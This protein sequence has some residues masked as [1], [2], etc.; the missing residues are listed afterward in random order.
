M[1]ESPR[2]GLL[3]V[4]AF[5]IAVCTAAVPVL[6]QEQARAASHARK[7]LVWRVD[8]PS[9][10]SPAYLAGSI[11]VLTAAHYPLNETMERAFGGA[12]TLVEEVHLDEL[13]SAEGAALLISKGTYTDGRT[14]ENTISKPT[15][16]LIVERLQRNGIPIAAMEHMKP[17]VIGLTL[18]ALEIQKSGFD[19]KL[20][21]DRHFFEKAKKAGKEIRALETVAYQ[22]ERFD[23]MPIATQ[24]QMLRAS[25]EDVETQLAN[26]KALADAWAAGDA[27]ATER[28]LLSSLKEAPHAYERLVAERNRNWIPA[29]D[30]CLQQAQPC[31]IVVGAAHVVGPDGLVT[32]LTR[33]GYR[34][35]QM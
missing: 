34:V 28:F 15:Y 17:W 7:S 9:G 19:P 32:L 5:L 24:E 20:G 13:L 8:A 26:V 21:V 25:L 2:R 22:I 27:S 10:R 11:H 14:L 6:T 31:F 12:R 33:K 29:I 18:M 23:G 1:I 30:A 16:D 3:R 4:A 35:E